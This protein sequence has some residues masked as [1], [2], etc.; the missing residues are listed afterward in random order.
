MFLFD[1][2]DISK[3]YSEILE[4]GLGV[5]LRTVFSDVYSAV[6]WV[7]GEDAE[8]DEIAKNKVQQECDAIE[9]IMPS[10][11]KF[12]K[13]G[14]ILIWIFRQIVSLKIKNLMWISVR[15]VRRIV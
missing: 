11:P 7:E 14:P 10:M 13:N 4:S 6:L 12:V 15:I 3:I 8:K 2:N 1:G 5:N 9:N